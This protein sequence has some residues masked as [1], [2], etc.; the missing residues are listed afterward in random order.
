M[1]FA[2]RIRELPRNAKQRLRCVVEWAVPAR[3][4]RPIQPHLAAIEAEVPGYG[5]RCG[6]EYP[7]ARA[8]VELPA[9]NLG[10]RKR[11]GMESQRMPEH[12]DP[13]NEV[14]AAFVAPALEQGMGFPGAH[15]A[16]RKALAPF[17][18]QLERVA[19]GRERGFEAGKGV[20]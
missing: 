7:G 17:V 3:G 9:E 1:L 4:A 6:G 16:A 5:K 14:G 12:L 19:Q 13:A 20:R 15:R 2:V 10:H 18:E 11:G 8:A